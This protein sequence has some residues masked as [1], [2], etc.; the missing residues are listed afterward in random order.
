[1]SI[2]VKWTSSVADP[3]CPDEYVDEIDTDEIAELRARKISTRSWGKDE[4][5]KFTCFEFRADLE[6]DRGNPTTI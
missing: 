2:I 6:I 3:P 5:G 4:K 1:M